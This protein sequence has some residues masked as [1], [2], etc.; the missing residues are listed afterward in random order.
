MWPKLN[1]LLDDVNS[2]VDA[3]DD[4]VSLLVSEVPLSDSRSFGIELVASATVVEL[5]R[6]GKTLSTLIKCNNLLNIMM[7]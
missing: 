4:P 7:P 6:A 2:D 5:Q 1:I 3:A